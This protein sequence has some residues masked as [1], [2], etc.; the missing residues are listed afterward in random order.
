MPKTRKARRPRSSKIS[1]KKSGG[2]PVGTVT[3]FFNQIN[4][5]VVHIDSG[6]IRL[7]DALRFKGHTTDFVQTVGSMQIN[8]QAVDKA[9]PG[10]AFGLRVK[11]RVRQGDQVF[12]INP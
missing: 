6:E 2:V 8:H 1:N 4:V 3:H 10:D 5:A 7:M 9:G 12:R 11:K